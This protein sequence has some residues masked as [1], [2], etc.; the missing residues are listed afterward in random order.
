MTF[1][2]Q[3]DEAQSEMIV[4]HAYENGV[5]FIDTADVYNEGRSEIYVGK[6]IKSFRDKVVLATKVGYAVHPGDEK[7]EVGLSRRHII[8]SLEDSLTR[9]GTD[10]IDFYY[11]HLPVYDSP[12]DE[13]LEALT[14]LVRSGKVRYIGVSNQAAWQI[15]EE[16]WRSDAKNHIAPVVTQNVCNMIT[17]GI[18]QELVPFLKHFKLGLVIYNPIAGGLLSGK[19]KSMGDLQKNTR[20]D[21][22]KMYLDRYWQAENFEAIEA[23][24]GIAEKNGMSLLELALRW[25]VSQTHVDAMLLGASKKEHIEQNIEFVNKGALDAAV[26]DDCDA[27]WND[28]AGNR[29]QYNR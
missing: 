28:L 13:T 22:N 12:L 4:K 6:A 25:C 10:Y 3:A 23:L 18:E 8:R 7:N 19:Y 29:A 26:L 1:G 14:C 15:C 20:F 21:G 24:R 16:L 27:V 5:N 11:M 9:L 17:R 2:G